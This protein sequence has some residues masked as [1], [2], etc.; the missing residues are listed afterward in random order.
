VP[1]SPTQIQQA[2][3]QAQVQAEQIVKD[4][5]EQ[6]IKVD[7]RSEMVAIIAYMQCLGLPGGG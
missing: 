6:K 1:Y 7:P 5:A 2:E 3:A 4:L